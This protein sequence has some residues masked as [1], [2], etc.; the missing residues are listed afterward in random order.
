[1]SAP[2]PICGCDIF[3]V[4]SPDDAYE[5]FEFRVDDGKVVWLTG[6]AEEMPEITPDTEVYCN[7]CAWHGK[8]SDIA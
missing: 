1:M 6:D 5:I 8:F 3:Y 4:K 7:I 2:C